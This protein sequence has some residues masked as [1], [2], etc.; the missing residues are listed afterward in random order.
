LAFKY[1]KSAKKKTSMNTS[2]MKAVDVNV[3]DD[4]NIVDTIDAKENAEWVEMLAVIDELE[5]ELAG[6]KISRN[7]LDEKIAALDAKI[8]VA[9]E[10]DEKIDGS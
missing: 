5:R 9:M 2:L 7:E 10:K 4:C 6:L 3:W 1:W 8:K